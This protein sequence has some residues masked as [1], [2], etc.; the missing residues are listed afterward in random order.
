MDLDYWSQVQ[1]ELN[2]V[3]PDNRFRIHV[4]SA[5][6]SRFFS[7]W[8]GNHQWL[9][10]DLI[11]INPKSWNLGKFLSPSVKNGPKKRNKNMLKIP[12]G[13]IWIILKIEYASKLLIHESKTFSNESHA[14]TISHW[15]RQQKI[16]F[17]DSPFSG[18]IFH[19]EILNFVKHFF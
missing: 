1:S 16:F 18:K 9:I 8:R 7:C 5:V 19:S 11:L 2:Q 3:F 15:F 13:R 14:I 10:S 17:Q 4:N 6:P 12:L